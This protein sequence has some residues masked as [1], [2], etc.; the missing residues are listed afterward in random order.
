MGTRFSIFDNGVNPERANA[1]WSNVRQELAAVI[2]VSNQYVCPFSHWLLRAWQ[3]FMLVGLC[4]KGME[5][6]GRLPSTVENCP[7]M[8]Q[9]TRRL[10]RR[11]SRN[12][13]QRKYAVSL[14]CEN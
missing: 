13:L 10:I 11:A 2:Y 3:A 7:S 5:G 12:M 1:D 14:L 9:R 4:P 8:A 6:G